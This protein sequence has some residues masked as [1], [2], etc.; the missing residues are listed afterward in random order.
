MSLVL[1]FSECNFPLL[2]DVWQLEEN[3]AEVLGKNGEAYVDGHDVG[4][5]KVNIF[6][7]TRTP[8]RLFRNVLAFLQETNH[9]QSLK[10]AY[11]SDSEEDYVPLWPPDLQTFSV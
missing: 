1:Q 10:A 5:G 2:E 6:I 3:I 7:V 8:K 11:R 4:E 9:A